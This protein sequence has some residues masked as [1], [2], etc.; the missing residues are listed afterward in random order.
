MR[1]I[2]LLTMILLVILAGYGTEETR[3]GTGAML[4]FDSFD[5]GG[6]V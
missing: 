3:E 1:K 6:E 4:T 2:V 5:G